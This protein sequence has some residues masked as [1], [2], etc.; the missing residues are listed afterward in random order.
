MI[1][2]SLNRKPFMSHPHNNIPIRRPRCNLQTLWQ[3]LMCPRQRMIP[4]HRN[5]LSNPLIYPSPIMFHNRR[6]SMHNFACKRD[7]SS[8]RRENTLFAH[9]HSQD[10]DFACEVEDCG[11]GYAGVGK[12]V[13]RTRGDDQFCWIESDKLFECYLVVSVGRDIVDAEGHDVF[14]DIV[15]ET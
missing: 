12:R 2:Y 14:D 10:G 9:T 8:E 3:S 5:I 13:A 11:G 1:L 6:L 7:C 4:R 15:C